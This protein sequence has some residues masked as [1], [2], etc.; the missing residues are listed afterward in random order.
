MIRRRVTIV[1][2]LACLLLW[3]TGCNS[4]PRP[5]ADDTL[6]GGGPNADFVDT[7]AVFGAGAAG[8]SPRQNQA[9]VQQEGILPSVFFAFDQSAIA[10]GERSK[11]ARAADYLFANP[12][13]ELLVEGHC[14]W[15]GTSEYNLA[16][17][18]RRANAVKRYLTS[19]GVEASRI[20]TTSR[21]DIESVEGAS[22]GQMSQDRRADL[23]VI[24]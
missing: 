10:P 15:R 6:V 20:D 19:L 9:G 21:G 14:D 17:G 7:T 2:A 11:L 24:Q 4:Q 1:A 23:I 3:V 5:S 8:L 18:D 13:A 22:D 16:L 12:N